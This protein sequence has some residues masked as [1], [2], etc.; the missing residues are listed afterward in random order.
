MTLRVRGVK[1]R[2]DGP[3]CGEYPGLVSATTVLIGA[4][5]LWAALYRRPRL[6]RLLF[7]AWILNAILGVQGAVGAL[8]VFG[9]GAL[10][11]HAGSPARDDRVTPRRDP[12]IPAGYPDG[13]RPGR[14]P[15]RVPDAA[16]RERVFAR[17]GYCCNYCGAGGPGVEL[18]ADHIV[19]WSEG[20]LTSDGNLCVL[21]EPCNLSKGVKS[22]A[23]A[24]EDYFRRT[25]FVPYLPP[26]HERLAA[27]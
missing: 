5:M 20:G 27:A 8:L 21:C 10:A 24:R 9:V 13:W 23:Q 6:R 25:G 16:L 19:P 15:I 14:D 26:L 11:E 7:A 17:D 18:H 1:V 4:A 3:A 12:R 2:L 22:D